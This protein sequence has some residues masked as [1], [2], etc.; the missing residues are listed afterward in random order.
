MKEKIFE[1][2]AN[3]GFK[4]DGSDD[5]GYVFDYE[6]L[7]L[8]YMYNQNDEDYFCICLPGFYDY[9]EAKKEQY[10]AL[11]EKINATLKYVKAYTLGGCMWLFYERELLDGE[12]LEALIR[13]M[14]FHLE[15]GLRFA[16]KTIMELEASLA[17]G[18]GSTCEEVGDD[19]ND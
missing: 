13:H 12:D 3:L 16:R 11:A 10:Q 15:A 19:D 18:S 17:D 7:H 8:I 1:A 4:L 9:E 2:F 5:T 6:N 14:I